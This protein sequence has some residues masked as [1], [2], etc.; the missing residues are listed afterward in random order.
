VAAAEA[1]R[2]LPLDELA[3]AKANG[4][5]TLAQDTLA[6]NREA[7]E[8]CQLEAFELTLALV[9]EQASV[10][11]Q[12]QEG[13]LDGVRAGL[14]ALLEFFDEE[15]QLAGYLVVHSA[16]AGDA[17][18]ERRAEVLGRIAQLL[19]D[20]RA[21]ARTYP[22]PLSAQ[23]VAS[24]VLGVLQERLA[25]RSSSPLVELAGELMSFTVLPFLGV[26]A[27]RRE[28]EG[29]RDGAAS[30][31]HDAGLAVVKDSTGR[32][33]PRTV[34]VLIVIGTEP[35]L[36]SKQV[37]ARAGV[38]DE[39]HCSR[40]LAR[41][42]RLGLIENA[43]DPGTRFAPKAWRLTAAGE[44][45]EV[46]LK[47]PAATDEHSS[48]FELP[49][50]LVGRLDDRA[51]TMLQAIGEQPW[52]RTAELAERA[53]V[54]DQAQ[55]T[56]L[57]ERLVDLGLAVG[58]L[59]AHQRGT[60]KVWSLTPAGEQLHSALGRETPAPPRSVVSELMHESGGRLSDTHVS[61]LRVL[62]GAPGLCNSE[63]AA[64]VGI[65][66]ENS[67]S[68]LLARLARRGLLANARNGGK[69]NVWSLTHTGERLERAIWAQTPPA[70]Q[71]KLAL[72]LVRDHG[73]RLNHRVVSV[74]RA[75]ASDPGQSN[76]EVA[77]RVGIEAKGHAST[78]LARLARFGL[79]ENLVVDPAPFEP[80]AWVLTASG[81]ELEAAIRGERRATSAR[82]L[83]SARRT[84]SSSTV[85]SGS[86]TPATATTT[87]ESK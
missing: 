83:R 51:V 81:T 29:A 70:Q 62:G 74:L 27:A 20:E 39:G 66:D 16:Q 56:K 17:V 64:R 19:D 44:K 28:L 67:A 40:L 13:W 48:A 9:S 3:L 6:A 18:L 33:S 79:I 12:A 45:L 42:E 69:H 1:L 60:P 59:E 5:A 43:R 15:P 24:G 63:I 22:P 55:P 2:K 53:G 57:L 75:L 21:P 77:E 52:L 7:S 23:A 14:T 25:R 37:A 50:E 78:L 41:L 35:G 71:R 73:G 46:S 26:R 31:D 84:T 87:K 11:F 49:P 8:A 4:R 72:D 86:R 38:K 80:N 61:V 58:E 30:Q 85:L 54:A 34:S 36:N 68:Q 82:A 76:L 47:R 65:T 10:A 32:L